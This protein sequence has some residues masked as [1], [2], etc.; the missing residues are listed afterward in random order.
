MDRNVAKQPL[1]FLNVSRYTK[2]KEG[3]VV[4]SSVNH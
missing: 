4:T 1:K 3:K 2:S